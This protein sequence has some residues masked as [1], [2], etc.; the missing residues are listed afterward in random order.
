MI[1]I[2]SRI[3]DSKG[4]LLPISFAEKP[5]KDVAFVIVNRDRRDLTDYLCAQILAFSNESNLTFDLYVVDIGSQPEGRS[6]Y[7]TIE[8]EDTHF[9]GKCYAHNVGIRQAA[10]AANYRYYWVMMND[11]RFDGQP[12]AMTRMVKLMEE[13]PELGLMSPTNVGV[14]KEYPGACPQIGQDF[15]KV[16]VCEYLS[17]MVRGEVLREVG[18][19]NPDFRY[20]WGAIHELSYK[21][22]STGKWALAYCDIVQF[23]HLGGTTYGKTK[24]VVSRQEYED[25]ARKFA[26]NYF[27]EHYGRDWDEKFTK[28]LPQDV[29]QREVYTFHRNY[30]ESVFPPEE[31]KYMHPIPVGQSL[32]GQIEALNPWYYPLR[33][34][35]IEVVPGIGS[36]ESAEGLRS[37][38]QYMGK[39]WIDLVKERYDFHGK[40]L[41][42][43]ASNCGYW[44]SKYVQLGASRFLGVEGRLDT[45]RQ[46]QLFWEQN[47]ILPQG[48]WEFIHGNVCDLETWDKIRRRGPFDF[49][50][51]CGILYHI[52]NYENLLEFLRSMTREAILVDTRVEEEEKY[53]QEPG[54]WKFDGIAETSYKKVP[55]LKR[56][57]SVLEGLGFKLEELT[58]PDPVPIGLLHLD[59]YSQKRRVTLLGRLD[60]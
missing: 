32:E 1:N 14:G 41:L 9:R 29:T 27:L 39:I 43:I 52:P 55:S 53:I 6:P 20:C 28:A 10:V 44:S 40:S 31:V 56:L 17:L 42:D 25:S 49:T 26:A 5:V 11:L 38:V 45:V 57:V 16:A 51:C 24:N 46:G 60:I 37:R 21:I 58:I 50:L 34:A 19:L 54:G 47:R 8:Y 18:F 15:R 13:H 4:Q 33:I 35:G 2:A 3:W 22:Y 7:T 59:D 48:D 23:E 12:L 36:R 30:F